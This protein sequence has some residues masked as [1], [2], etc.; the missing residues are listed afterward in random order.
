[1]L[2]RVVKRFINGWALGRQALAVVLEHPQL[3]LFPILSACA[4]VFLTV[5]GFYAVVAFLQ[6]ALMMPVAWAHMDQ[7]YHVI[8]AFAFVVYVLIWF[9]ML[10]LNTALTAT[11]L[12]H[13]ADGRMS[14]SEGF[15]IAL[16]RLGCLLQWALFAATIGVLIGMLSRMLENNLGWV[17]RWIGNAIGATWALAIYFIVPVLA[18]EGVGPFK[19]IEKSIE[20]VKRKWGQAVGIEAAVTWTLWPLHLFGLACVLGLKQLPYG[21][22]TQW[23]GAGLII[24]TLTAIAL[25]HLLRTIARSHLYIFAAY[26]EVPSG[27]N[28]EFYRS[29][30]RK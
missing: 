2:Q 4:L 28:P 20:T 3:I 16:R 15:A 5:G 12:L 29:L 23:L 21:P 24:Y 9:A 30:G 7:I 18:V 11:I 17:G 1:M 26:D 22:I 10:F 14:M 27:G 25:T 6:Q 8:L 19:G 13:Q